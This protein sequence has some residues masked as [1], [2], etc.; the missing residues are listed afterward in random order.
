MVR[1]VS[2]VAKHF[3][4]LKFS[5]LQIKYKSLIV[6]FKYFLFYGLFQ[7][8]HDMNH[9]VSII[10]RIV[11]NC[12]DMVIGMIEVFCYRFMSYYVNIMH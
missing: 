5:S 7:T 2:E 12:L 9:V 6:D 10:T 3:N 1:F 4:L 8:S 11:L